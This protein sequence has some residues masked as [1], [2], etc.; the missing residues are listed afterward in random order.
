M[1]FSS[2]DGDPAGRT[3]LK[4]GAELDFSTSRSRFSAADEP[5]QRE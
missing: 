5:A 1:V 3:H 2:C 4:D